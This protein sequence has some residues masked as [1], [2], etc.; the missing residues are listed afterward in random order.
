MALRWSRAI[1]LTSIREP[2]EAV[3]RHVLESLQAAR[4][5]NACAGGILDVGSG[6]GYPALP[7]K[8]L[9]PSLSLT[10]LEPSLRKSVFLE[11][12]VRAMGLEDVE[13]RRER[14]DRPADLERYAGVG[15]ITM[16]G[17][18]AMDPVVIGGTKVLPP[19]GRIILVTS[20]N[21]VESLLKQARPGLAPI[22]NEDVLPRRDVRILV[23][24]RSKSP[25]TSGS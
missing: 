8:C 7:A 21:R 3:R 13:V 24:E 16:R 1:S 19:G 12:A 9:H 5:L 20:R 4:H 10:L 15:N 2:E 22:A 6:N 17:V 18:G 25:S 11:S 23:L 14:V